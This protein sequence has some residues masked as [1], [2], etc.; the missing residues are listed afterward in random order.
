[1]PARE[2]GDHFYLLHRRSDV[3]RV[4]HI[5]RRIRGGYAEAY[6]NRRMSSPTE[7]IRLPST[8]AACV[9]NYNKES[10]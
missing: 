7:T 2:P 5:L 8:C 10:L 3:Q 9:R 1:M 4:I 6:C